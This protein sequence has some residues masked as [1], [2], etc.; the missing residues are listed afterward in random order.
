MVQLLVQPLEVADPV[1]IGVEEGLDVKLVDY[2]I[3]VPQRVSNNLS[4]RLQGIHS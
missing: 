1:A 2:R 4:L 3:L